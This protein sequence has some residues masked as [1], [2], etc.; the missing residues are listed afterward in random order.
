M[1]IIKHILDDELHQ[2]MLDFFIE[3]NIN[4][5]YNIFKTIITLQCKYAFTYTFQS[6]F[7]AIATFIHDIKICHSP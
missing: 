2:D 5:N 7:S 3:K 6:L 4:T 1:Y